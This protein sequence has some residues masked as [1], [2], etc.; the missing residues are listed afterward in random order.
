LTGELLPVCFC[1][2]AR[3]EVEEA[4]TRNGIRRVYSYGRFV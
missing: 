1:Y 4:A 2:R 3:T